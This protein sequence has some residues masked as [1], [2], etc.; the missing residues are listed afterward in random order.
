MEVVQSERSNHSFG[1]LFHTALRKG[2]DTKW[3]VVWWNALYLIQIEGE[4]AAELGYSRP[5]DV[6][7]HFCK[8][9][10]RWWVEGAKP[11]E[12]IKKWRQEYGRYPRSEG[13]SEFPR[14]NG[15]SLLIAM[16][17]LTDDDTWHDIDYTVAA[18]VGES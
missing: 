2:S 7:S 6:W 11:S 3:S 12:A 18:W 5:Q 9:C 8:H 13:V 10:Q 4:S 17:D 1:E 14:S 16:I 15:M